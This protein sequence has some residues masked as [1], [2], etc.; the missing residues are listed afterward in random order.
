MLARR[1]RRGGG[2]PRNV[3]VGQ[4]GGPGDR[5]HDGS[6]QA[7]ATSSDSSAISDHE[8]AARI[9][10]SFPA[11]GVAFSYLLHFGYFWEVVD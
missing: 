2:E 4:Y 7:D 11:Y 5:H 8:L 10:T 9:R 6:S 1:L 3:A